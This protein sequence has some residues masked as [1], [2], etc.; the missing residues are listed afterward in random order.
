M[1]NQ[2]L[3]SF[4]VLG[5][6]FSGAS[7]QAADK[8]AGSQIETKEFPAAGLKKVEAT[9][10]SG[11]IRIS[12]SD[13]PQ[14]SVKVTKTLWAPT[15][16]LEIKRVGDRLL[17]RVQQSGFVNSDDCRADLEIQT[18]K[19]V[20]LEIAEGS[21]PVDLKGIEGALSFKIGSG[22]LTGDGHFTKLA[23]QSGSGDVNLTGVAGGGKLDSGS[24]D[25]QL[26]FAKASLKG[27]L[28][29][30]VA[31]GNAELLFPKGSKVQTQLTAVSGKVTNELG[32]AKN[33]DFKVAMKAASGNLTIKSY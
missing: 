30:N 25:F 5:L 19:N 18:P 12:A 11:A 27:A 17:V 14:A 20:D 33:A 7:S 4:V 24:G 22:N 29:I 16:V 21:G 8:A 23:G 13:A 32:E 28:E 2:S 1:L 26:K 10:R 3:Q 6:V 15:C 9:N 31:S